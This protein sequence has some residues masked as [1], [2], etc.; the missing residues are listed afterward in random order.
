MEEGGG[1]ERHDVRG[2]EALPGDLG[3]DGEDHGEGGRQAGLRKGRQ[4]Q[5][6]LVGRK[7]HLRRSYA[8]V[9][10][11]SLRKGILP[12]QDFALVRRIPKG[13]SGGMSS[14]VL[15]KFSTFY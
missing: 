6:H 13:R 4:Q 9:W 12:G 5:Q 14:F 3:G 10:H 8:H 1:Q 15:P 2:A 11:V 7:L